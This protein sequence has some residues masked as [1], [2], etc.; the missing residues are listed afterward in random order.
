[1]GICLA[2]AV[3]GVEIDLAP[4]QPLPYVYVD[5]P[6][7]VGIR[8]AEDAQ[9]RVR[10]EVQ[11]THQAR[12]AVVELGIV[13]LRAHGSRWCAVK[14]LPAERGY[15]SVQVTVD[16]EGETTES[17]GFFCRTDRPTGDLALPLYA[18]GREPDT[19]S[20][21]A[22]GTASVRTVRLD[23]SR[24]DIEERTAQLAA[25]G[26][27]VVLY[28]DPATVQEP[29]PAIERIASG[30]CYAITRWEIEAHGDA[31]QLADTAELIRHS[32]CAAP[33]AVLVT[34][35]E[36]LA[37]LLANDAGR[38]VREAVLLDDAPAPSA[39]DALYRVAERA[40]YEAWQVHVLG[41]GIARDAPVSGWSLVRQIL[42]NVAAGVGQTGFDPALV[43][44]GTL[45]EALVYLNGLAR[46]LPGTDYVG[47]LSPGV[48]VF[49]HARDWLVVLTDRE[50]GR[51]ISLELGDAED[52]LLSDALANALP[53]PAASGGRVVFDGG[54]RPQYL[55]GSGGS[56]LGQAARIRAHAAAQ[57]FIEVAAYR[58]YLGGDW[59]QVVKEI[60]E[61]TGGDSSR[62]QFLALI[63]IFPELERQWHAGELPRAIAVPVI[64]HVA[65]LAQS[66]CTV[67]EDRGEAFLEPLPD[68]LL[69]CKEYQ[70]LYLTGSVGTAQ[71]YNRGDWM[72]NEVQRLMDEAETLSAAG[73][74]IEAAAVAALAEW[75]A[76]SLSYAA[77]AG[78]VPEAQEEP[79]AA[80]A[81]PAP[82]VAADGA[83]SPE[84]EAAAVKEMVERP[85]PEAEEPALVPEIREIVHT[86]ARGDNPSRIAKQYGVTVEDFLEWN[87]LTKRSI[88]SIGDKY[89]IR[90]SA[91]EAEEGQ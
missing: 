65:G 19:R 12:P 49:R 39:V 77:L 52:L 60:A 56:V 35:A 62:S 36:A 58:R 9:A 63:R 70:S 31:R 7:I 30:L 24:P 14:D 26:F 44:G 66:L 18:W 72:L 48:P 25:A 16:I 2:L 57:A 4:D 69:R 42:G 68:T 41:R 50:A 34:D 5:D 75:R 71:A 8:G 84:P 43:Y 53:L 55:T 89:V 90:L 37:V 22:L 83:G 17:R 91:A 29:G 10:L 61:D 81:P 1:M 74:R 79:D 85:A 82:E 76:R 13:L 87:G 67:E 78:T 46:R 3:S 59:M 28:V 6:L 11:A 51:E 27:E 73:S 23:L 20:Q 88:L 47:E 33:L 64:G 45:G 32:G 15:Y 40:G 38:H 21:L 54:G 86:V 80:A